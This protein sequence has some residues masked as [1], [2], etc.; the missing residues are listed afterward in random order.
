M[1][2]RLEHLGLTKLP[3]NASG[4]GN[5]RVPTYVPRSN[6]RVSTRSKRSGAARRG[7]FQSRLS[8]TNR[9]LLHGIMSS[10]AEFYSQKL[11]NEVLKGTQQKASSGGTPR[12]A[13]IGY[14]NV[15]EEVA[16][17]E[18]RTIVIDDE[19]AALVR[20]AFARGTTRHIRGPRP[21]V[22]SRSASSSPKA[23]SMMTK[24][25]LN[26]DLNSGA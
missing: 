2:R 4:T 3:D 14:R 18:V 15:R 1:N 24:G 13:P 16:G 20:W 23:S 26:R 19:R 10:I 12:D 6:P 22:S 9:L 11:A 21:G 8:G 7:A 17:R 25:R 5:Q